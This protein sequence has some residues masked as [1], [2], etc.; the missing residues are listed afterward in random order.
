MRTIAV[1]CVLAIAALGYWLGTPGPIGGEWLG[2]AIRD[3]RGYDHALGCLGL[4]LYWLAGTLA[5]VVN[6]PTIVVITVAAVIYD[7]GTAIFLGLACL[8]SAAW[9]IHFIGQRI[10]RRLVGRLFARHMPRLENHFS[11]SGLAT[12]IYARLAFFALP[13]VNWALAVMNIRARDYVLG[14]AIGG[15]PH[16]LA[17]AWV[18]GTAAELLARGQSLER[19]TGLM[20][21]LLLGA[22][23]ILLLQLSRRFIERRDG[24]DPSS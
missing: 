8:A 20:V 9:C 22:G 16:V 23:L 24:A 3:V 18:T 1:L 7:A 4:P 10:G 6:I 21:P 12:V 19:P 5:I 2:G 13:P 14:T 15:L 11:R 17:W